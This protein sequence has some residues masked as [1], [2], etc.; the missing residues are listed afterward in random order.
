MAQPKRRAPV[1]PCSLESILAAQARMAQPPAHE[2]VH[3]V[4]R[5]NGGALGPP[6]QA[7]GPP[8]VHGVRGAPD[9]PAAAP[10]GAPGA[11][12]RGNGR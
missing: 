5:E 8:G 7:D 11:A 3:D 2:R 1:D 10:P 4:R 6:G 12:G 9:A